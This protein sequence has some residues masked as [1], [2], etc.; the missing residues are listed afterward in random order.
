MVLNGEFPSSLLLFPLKL[1][2]LLHVVVF[3]NTPRRRTPQPGPL[4]SRAAEAQPDLS[5][6]APTQCP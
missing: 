1:W 3:S 2:G 5:P 6:N 4:L